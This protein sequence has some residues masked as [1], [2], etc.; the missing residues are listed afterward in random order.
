MLVPQIFLIYPTDD[1][2]LDYF[3]AGALRTMLI[4]W[5]IY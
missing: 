1:G 5:T 4:I 3:Q 2:Y